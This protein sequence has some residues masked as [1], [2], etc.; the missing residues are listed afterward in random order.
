MS[1]WVL[2]PLI[3]CFCNLLLILVVLVSNWRAFLHRILFIFLFALGIWAFAVF[4]LRVSP[5]LEG[6]LLWQRIA[7]GVGPIGAV[8]YY[9]FTSLLTRAKMPKGFPHIGYLLAIL[10]LFLVPTDLL[11]AGNQL[12]FYGP[13]PVLGKLFFLYIA[14]LYSFASLGVINLLRAARTSPSHEERNRARY[15]IF[16][17]FCFLL[18]GLSDFLPVIGLH[19]YPM[20]MVGNLL[21]C[22]F[23]TIAIVRHHLLD[24]WIVARKGLAYGIVSAL[25]IGVYVGLI[26]LV[27]LLWGAQPIPLWANIGIVFLLAIALQPVLGRVQRLVDRWFYQERYGPLKALEQFTRQSQ[28]VTDLES[29]SSALTKTVALAM[30]ARN[31]Y[32]ML[33]SPQAGDFTL[34]S[35]ASGES[36]NGSPLPASS[37]LLAWMRKNDGFLT[38][39]DLDILPQL[40]ALKTSERRF[41]D[42]LD[43]EIYIPLKTLSGL[44]GVL[45]LTA[46]LS[47]QPYSSEDIDLL[48]TLAR[49]AAMSIENARLY[50]EEKERAFELE[51]LDQMK[52]DFLVMVS[53]QL[54]TPLTSVKVAA[55]MLIEQEE[56]E[57]SPLRRTLVQTL[58]MGVEALQKL[59]TEIVDL[60]KIRAATL[61]LKR[62][63]FDISRL[64]K[65]EVALITPSVTT[66]EQSLELELPDYLPAVLIDRERLRQ[67]LVNLLSNANKFTPRGGR[68]TVRAREDGDLGVVVEVEDTGPGIPEEEQ[69]SIFEPYYQ[70]ADASG[71][72]AG[73]GLGLAI[74]KSLV[75]LH[76]GKIWIESRVGEGSTFSFSIPLE[77]AVES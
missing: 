31:A 53:H 43:G 60:A 34:Y 49:Q 39:K 50:A 9:H 74:A 45:I 58:G 33:P 75:E 6:A 27:T 54:K 1:L 41:L 17:T 72:H 46:R 15:V 73:S 66:K 42:Q 10:F 55:D 36:P 71:Y 40:K 51:K 5:T 56:R 19:I 65:D 20:G 26:F 18:G 35:Y 47:R 69:Q 61:E 13:A 16:G 52:S 62:E 7:L 12:R 30:Q 25:V 8:L 37:A 21:F 63:P 4:A 32:L 68:I 57:P 38:H 3:A 59:I 44:T 23:A 48:W 2:V 77:P 67:V 28:S 29:L 24:I 22:L 14:V 11:V 64:V 76:G 70:V